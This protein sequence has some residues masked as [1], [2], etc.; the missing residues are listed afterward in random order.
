V[1]AR[2]AALDEFGS[3]DQAVAERHLL[4]DIGIVAR[5]SEPLIDDVDEADVVAAIEPGVHQIRSIDVEDHESCGSGRGAVLSHAVIM[6]NGCYAV[7]CGGSADRL[8][9]GNAAHTLR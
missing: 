2:P 8:T 9:Q 1:L 7:P 5:P 6:T 4:D 3:G